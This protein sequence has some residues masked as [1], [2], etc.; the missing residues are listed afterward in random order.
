M[1][2]HRNTRVVDRDQVLRS[3]APPGFSDRLAP[4]FAGI[5]VASTKLS[6]QSRTP[7]PSRP[8]SNLRQVPLMNPGSCQA[9]NLHQHVEELGY[10]SG[11]SRHRA[12][13]LSIQ[14]I[15]S[16]Q[17]RSSAGGR[18][19]FAFGG[20]GR[21]HGLILSHCLSTS[22]DSRPLIG[23]PPVSGLREICRKYKILLY[24]RLF[25]VTPKSRS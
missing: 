10:W 21:I 1:A 17:A 5:T 3:L 18:P 19:P 15:P 12:P 8:E 7:C 24:S 2:F 13:V 25:A 23:A 4:L 20:C 9:F 16:K 22:V 14:K 11:R 6:S